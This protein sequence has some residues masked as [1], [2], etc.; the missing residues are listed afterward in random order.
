MDD[1]KS[2]LQAPH[3]EEDDVEIPGMGTVHV[4]ALNRLDAIKVQAEKSIPAAERLIVSLGMTNPKMTPAE[5]GRWQRN[6]PA[7]EVGRVSD[8]IAIIS[9]MVEGAAKDRTKEFIADP[10]LE[11]R[12]VPGAEAVY[13]GGPDEGG[14]E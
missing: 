6:S 9:G 2:R 5:V 12:D 8:R 10:A 1:L 13:D 4:R 11:F 14:A 7:G 3:L